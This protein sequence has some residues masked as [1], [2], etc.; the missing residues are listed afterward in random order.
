MSEKEQLEQQISVLKE[1]HM[2]LNLLEDLIAMNIGRGSDEMKS[3]AE[4][5]ET[6]ELFVDRL[7]EK[8]TNLS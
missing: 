2:N 5:Q 7:K 3:V 4:V 6:I 1:T 8:I